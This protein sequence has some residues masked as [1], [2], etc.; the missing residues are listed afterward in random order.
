M[1]SSL[2][3]GQRPSLACTGRNVEGQRSDQEGTVQLSRFVEIRGSD[4]DKRPLSPFTAYTI[5][6]EVMHIVIK[7]IPLSH[8]LPV[9]K[10]PEQTKINIHITYTYTSERIFF[11]TATK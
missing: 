8:T 2:Q 7:V 9:P 11:E 3:G 5:I 6:E 4:F 1:L 10:R